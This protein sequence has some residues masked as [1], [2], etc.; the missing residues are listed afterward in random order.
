MSQTYPNQ[1]ESFLR[2]KTEIKCASPLFLSAQG[3]PPPS[4]RTTD[5]D[6]K[7]PNAAKHKKH[8]P[9]FP[10]G[11]FFVFSPSNLPFILRKF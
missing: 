11:F 1:G 5:P 6:R 2:I 3:A 7:S 10:P 4:L 8:K 9:F